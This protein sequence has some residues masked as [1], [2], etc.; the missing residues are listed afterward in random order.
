MRKLMHV[1]MKYVN[2]NIVTDIHDFNIH[3]HPESFQ[4]FYA[5]I[6]EIYVTLILP[7]HNNKQFNSSG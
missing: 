2:G 4:Y 7:N 3:S 1:E 5:Q 6:K